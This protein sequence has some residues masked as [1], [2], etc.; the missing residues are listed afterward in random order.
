MEQNN[1]LP[2][3]VN[4]I[5]NSYKNILI[6]GNNSVAE[7][8]YQYLTENKKI[9]VQL[10]KNYVLEA[11]F[12]SDDTEIVI[13]TENKHPMVLKKNGKNVYYVEYEKIVEENDTFPFMD[14]YN[15]IV[16][17]LLSEGVRFLIVRT[18]NLRN[19]QPK[20][21]L[22]I[23]MY[24]Y[25]QI[26][27]YLSNRDYIMLKHLKSEELLQEFKAIKTDNLK[28]Y[29]RVHG[30]GKFI[31]YDDG[32]RRVPCVKVIE[33]DARHIYLFGYCISA[34]PMLSDNETI[35]ANLQRFV[36]GNYR[37]CSRGNDGS[38]INFIMRSVRYKSGDIVI[39]FTSHHDVQ[40]EKMGLDIIDLTNIYLQVP[41]LWKHITDSSFHI[42]AFL[43]K[44]IAK[45]LSSR[46]VET[47][48]KVTTE[49]CLGGGNLGLHKYQCI[50][51]HT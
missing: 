35:A 15:N 39:L 16:G 38:A 32:W 11:L 18:P 26:S 3:F 30:N 49:F 21:P 9:D 48:K 44:K 46:V 50:M 7:C 31:N 12:V 34:N 5:E 8:I 43:A 36:G 40:P 24:L 25:R 22:Y 6:V 19:Y 45:E 47:T 13:F 37:V 28:G 23:S 33:E 14:I 2:M 42:D 29:N 51:I 4:T 1:V 27:K 20:I 41:K 17:K 10:V